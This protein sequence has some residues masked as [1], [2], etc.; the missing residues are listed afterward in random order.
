[1]LWYKLL[2]NTIYCGK[3]HFTSY[4]LYE[5]MSLGRLCSDQQKRGGKRNTIEKIVLMP[6]APTC[7]RRIIKSN[8]LDKGY[9]MGGGLVWIALLLP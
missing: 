5:C 4:Q 3:L 9:H 7:C 1:M 8:D 6:L 2:Q